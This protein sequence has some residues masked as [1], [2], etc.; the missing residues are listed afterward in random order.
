MEKIKNFVIKNWLTLI[1]IIIVIYLFNSRSAS[2]MM[3]NLNFG[4]T[5]TYD[6]TMPT[7]G[8]VSNTI[9]TAKEMAIA[10]QPDFA[11]Q[12][13]V[14][15]RMVIQN[16]DMSLL[17]KNVPEARDQIIGYAESNGGYMVNS[18]VSNPTD[19]PSATIVV[20]IK[21]AKIKEALDFFRSISVKVVNENLQGY[22]VT[23]QYVDV[24]KRIAILEESKNQI[25]NILTSAREVSDIS[26]L[27]QQIL[28]LQS[29]I[30]SYKGQQEALTKNA[31]LAKVSIYLS[32]DEIALPY[33]PNDTFRPAVIFK[34]AIRSLVSDLRGLATKAIWLV[35][36]SVI[37]IPILVIAFLAYKY[38][39]RKNKYPNNLRG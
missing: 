20:R 29:Q 12:A 3:S 32:T 2:P 21:S 7:T 16:S 15:N 22:D 30:D 38:I 37:W 18:N 10:P 26:N 35:V 5:A 36:Y 39:Y 27:T 11:P 4:R 28:N 19:A 25:Q 14:T 31:D 6:M 8:G 34:L 9:G 13:E 17:V 24:E 1:L 23:D 33:A